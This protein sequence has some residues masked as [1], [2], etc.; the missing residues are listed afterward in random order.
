MVMYENIES[1]LKET[2]KKVVEV[3]SKINYLFNFI[4][5]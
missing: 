5:N 1:I 2:F 3:T 4:Y